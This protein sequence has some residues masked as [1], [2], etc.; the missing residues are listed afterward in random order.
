MKLQKFYTEKKKS[1]ESEST[2]KETFRGSG[3]GQN[4]PIILIKNSI[5]KNGVNIIDFINITQILNSKSEIRRAINERGIKINDI[6]VVD[7]KKII[8]MN[9][10]K[11]DFIKVSYGKKKHYRIKLN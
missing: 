1:K 5:L 11:N 7:D 8:D 6:L 2:A 4:L 3:I 9:D 10:L